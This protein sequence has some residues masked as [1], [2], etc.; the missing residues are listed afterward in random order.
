MNA[1]ALV[2][3][4]KTATAGSVI[5]IRA[6]IQH[7]M[8]TG[9]RPLPNGGLVPRHVIDRFECIYDGETVFVAELHPAI[10]ANPYIAFRTVATRS[11]ELVFRWTDDR[12]AVREER[13]AITVT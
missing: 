1:R 3:V 4:P 2:N 12:G 13:A 9:F 8:E 10:A 7:P 5:E 11:G 6:L